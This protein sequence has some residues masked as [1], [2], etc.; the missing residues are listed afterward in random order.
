MNQPKSGK[1][2]STPKNREREIWKAVFCKKLKNS[3]SYLSKPSSKQIF[4]PH[5]DS[6]YH[7]NKKEEGFI[8]YAF[9]KTKFHSIL[10]SGE[11]MLRCYLLLRKKTKK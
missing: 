1:N 9:D 7:K 11:I 8:S 3:I 5:I 4:F 6:Q 2:A 10:Y